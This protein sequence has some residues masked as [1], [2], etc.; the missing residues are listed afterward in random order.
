MGSNDC[1]SSC[2]KLIYLKFLE[3]H[4]VI[5]AHHIK[6]VWDCILVIVSMMFP[7]EDCQHFM[8]SWGHHVESQ[9]FG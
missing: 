2:F 7:P 3:M 6:G 5:W 8:G 4:M 1:S 9:I